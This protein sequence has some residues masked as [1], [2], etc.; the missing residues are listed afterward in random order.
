MFTTGR[1]PYVS[2]TNDTLFVISVFSWQ[3]TGARQ[4][5]THLAAATAETKRW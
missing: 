2:V 3:V 1:I 4:V 5:S